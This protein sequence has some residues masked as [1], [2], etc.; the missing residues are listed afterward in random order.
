MRKP[1][2]ACTVG[3]TIFSAATAVVPS[4]LAD[5]HSPSA[6][7]SRHH[8]ARHHPAL[9]T[10]LEDLQTTPDSEPWNSQGVAEINGIS[11]PHSLGVWFCGTGERKSIFVLGRKYSSL[12]GT[13]GLSD[14]SVSTARVR[15][16]ILA[17][18]RPLYS[19]DLQLGQST[20]LNVP[21]RNVLQ[22]EL[23]TTSLTNDCGLY[24][25]WGNIHVVGA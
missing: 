5:T 8:P 1:I 10:Y 15:F 25:E 16:E 7:L 11:Y 22:L 12:Q 2:G 23:D 18:G 21:V 3:L 19:K 24:G 14:N 13:I 9:V 20:A 17:G 6:A 4:A